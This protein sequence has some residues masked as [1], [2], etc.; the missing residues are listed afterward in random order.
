M[1]LST[2]TRYGMSLVIDL[3]IY[4]KKEPVLLKDVSRRQAISLKYLDHILTALKIAGIVRNV[5]GGHGGYMLTKPAEKIYAYEVVNAL[6]GSL[7]PLEC[8]KDPKSCKRSGKCV[9]HRLWVKAKDAIKKTL[10]VTLAELAK[11]QMKTPFWKTGDRMAG[12]RG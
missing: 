6:E 8:V 10:T 9:Q 3:A 5:G 4:A 7:S 12:D 1:K 11:E 2:K